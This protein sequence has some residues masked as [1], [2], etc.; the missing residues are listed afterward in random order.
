MV[1]QTKYKTK[2]E[3]NLRSENEPLMDTNMTLC[4][5]RFDGFSLPLGALDMLCHFIVTNTSSH[6]SIHL[7]ILSFTFEIMTTKKTIVFA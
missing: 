3:D 2:S 7:Q 1:I 4:R 5:F 6:P